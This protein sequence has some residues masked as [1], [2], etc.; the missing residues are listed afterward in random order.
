MIN[1]LYALAEAIEK[2][3][4]SPYEW[5]KDL[6]DLPRVSENKPLYRIWFSTD[7]RIYRIDTI[8]SQTRVEGSENQ[9][10]AN[11]LRK[12]EKNKGDAFPAFNLPNLYKL[13]GKCWKERIAEKSE[14]VSGKKNI[15]F[16][17]LESWLVEA[18][19][20]WEVLNKRKEP[21][22]IKVE[23]CLHKVPKEMLTIISRYINSQN[24]LTD[25]IRLLEGLSVDAFRLA[26]KTYI[27]S[28]LKKC[29]NV[30]PL[31]NFLFSETQ[32]SVILDLEEYSSSCPVA[33]QT[34]IKWLNET[35]IK[36]SSSGMEHKGNQ[37]NRIDAFGSTYT[38]V[39]QTMPEVKLPGLGG[40]KLRSMFAAHD[41]QKRYGLIEDSSYPIITDNRAKI[42]KA[43]EWLVEE[44]RQGKTWGMVDAKEILF[45]YPSSIPPVMPRFTAFLG[46]AGSASPE[47]FDSRAKSVFQTIRGLPQEKQPKNIHIFAIH[48]MDKARSKVVF[49]RTYSI[50][51]LNESAKIW[52][53][54]CTNVPVLDIWVWSDQG[55]K[56]GPGTQ[57]AV[58]DEKQKREILQLEAIEPLQ[59]AKVI[60][61]AW[62]M[63]GNLM[64]TIPR[65]KYYQ[66]IE[67]FFSDM[68]TGEI[69][70]LLNVLLTNCSGLI[71]YLGNKTHERTVLKDKEKEG[72]AVL[73][74]LLGLLL[75]KQGCYEEE[76]MKNMPY[77]IGQL[78]KVA[79]ELHAFYCKVLRDG[80]VPPQLVGNALFVAATETP[81]RALTQLSPR[82]SPYLAWAKQYRTKK[83]EEKEKESWRAAWYID[84]LESISTNLCPYITNPVESIQRFNDLEK[85]QLFIGY[86]AKFPKRE[87]SN[88]DP[89][90][91]ISEEKK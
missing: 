17:K 68:P 41:C 5:H 57:G 89:Q 45:A 15:D 40:V 28:E 85:A 72:C 19:D 82:I 27:F 2:A 46:A 77:Q 87:K 43:L 84:L 71:H 3:G 9:L 1:E 88:Q 8:T 36:A 54:G 91:T 18:T 62:K 78:L 56:E 81:V 14:W 52:Q 22:K 13:E 12:W 69:Q 25:L 75:Y 50:Q 38:E 4:I 74:P 59:T 20:N 67:L 39:G 66:G 33:H 34:T 83:I 80:K 60:N 86:L 73:F 16:D 29:E 63:D 61:K 24:A 32:L 70:H 90:G 26:L 23:N 30:K 47:K 37:N 49:Y 51:N 53:A 10:C 44:E 11:D 35:L 31:L 21:Q 7:R 76:Y 79:D 42:K 6:K 64:G 55:K 48:K 65:I 58:T